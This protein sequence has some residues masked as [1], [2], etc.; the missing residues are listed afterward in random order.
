[1]SFGKTHNLGIADNQRKRIVIVGGGFAGLNLIRKLKNSDYQIVLLDSSNHHTFQHLLYQ[2][3][4][5]ELEASAIAYP[6]RKLQRTHSDFHF[7][8]ATVEEIRARDSHVVTD[9][10]NLRYDYLVLASGAITKF[11]GMESVARHAMPMKTIGDALEI[12]NRLLE[13]LEKAQLTDNEEEIKKLATIV[14]AGGGP[15]GVETAGAVA[16]FK[17]YVMSSDY[18]DMDCDLCSIYLIEML[19]RI[20]APMSEKASQ[21]ARSYL[22]S[23]GVK[24]LTDTKIEHFDGELTATDTIDIPTQILIWTGGVAGAAIDGLADELVDKKG[25]IAADRYGR[26]KGYD[27]I[28]AIGDVA[29]F[30][31]DVYAEGHPQL[32]AV[33]VQQGS[34][35]ASCFRKMAKG[36]LP[37]PFSYKDKGVMAN[38]GR[39]KG[40]VQ[41]PNGTTYKGFF[42][43]LG[44]LGVTLDYLAGFKNR[45]NTII[46]WLWFALSKDM[47][48]RIILNTSRK[49]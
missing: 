3:A 5:S 12:R 4:A 33:A 30:D 11:F 25:R 34:Y 15:A 6:L 31:S 23:M 10:G 24:V 47:A 39:K 29:R 9:A 36:R 44:W 7:R 18:T 1:M 28:Y 43:W 35:L 8:M 26:V 19:P 45:L 32:A 46:T 16:E 41:L 38:I 48:C 42:P 22:A 13:N 20:L 37:K 2:V 17:N 49:K 27:N 40:I 21:Q 14:I